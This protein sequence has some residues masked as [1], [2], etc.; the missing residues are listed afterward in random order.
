VPRS[1]LDQVRLSTN[2]CGA[3]LCNGS[4]ACP[5]S[6]TSD[7]GCAADS[8]CAAGGTCQPRKA[9][10]GTCNLTADCLAPGCASARAAAAWTASAATRRAPAAATSA[11][12]RW[13]RRRTAGAPR[14]RPGRQ[15]ACGAYLCSGAA[16][17]SCAA[18]TQWCGGY[19]CAADGV[20]CRTSCADTA[21]CMS[22]TSA[23]ARSAREPRRWA[24]R[25]SPGAGLRP[26]ARW[27]AGALALRAGAPVR[28]MEPEA[29]WRGCGRWRGTSSAGSQNWK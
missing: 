14:C 2:G 22:A 12:R 15:P 18:E 3:Y 1:G 4:A 13:G 6:C 5:T 20:T 26:E 21:E 17:C 23:R 28:P 29:R 24:R 16:D 27:G 10:G 19:Q 8:Y 9:V 7:E 11:R 25:A